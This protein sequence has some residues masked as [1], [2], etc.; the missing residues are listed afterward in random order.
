LKPVSAKEAETAEAVDKFID[1]KRGWKP[2]RWYG[3]LDEP[4]RDGSPNI[5][6]KDV[7]FVSVAEIKAAW[8]RGEHFGPIGYRNDG[9]LVYP[10]LVKEAMRLGYV[11]PGCHNRQET[12][13]VSSE[14]K[15]QGKSYGCG[16]VRAG[17]T[18][19]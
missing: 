5:V 15:I 13:G 16:Y 17:S 12:P 3:N 9:T 8:E 14:C 18:G 11:C 10:A 6:Q 1:A 19:W 2:S 7:A 4:N